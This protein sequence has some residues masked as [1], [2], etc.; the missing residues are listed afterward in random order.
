MQSRM[1]LVNAGRD[2]DVCLWCLWL[3]LSGISRAWLKVT[4]TTA[5]LTASLAHLNEHLPLAGKSIRTVLMDLRCALILI[6]KI[7]ILSPSSRPSNRRL[8]LCFASNVTTLATILRTVIS[9][10]QA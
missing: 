9:S 4:C 2:Q 6:Q 10:P 5:A 1:S 3:S 8:L 7:R